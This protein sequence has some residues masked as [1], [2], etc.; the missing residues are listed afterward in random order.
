[1]FSGFHVNLIQRNR[2][3]S[4]TDDQAPLNEQS[5]QLMNTIRYTLCH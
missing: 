4:S 3:A 2:K 5:G 1:M